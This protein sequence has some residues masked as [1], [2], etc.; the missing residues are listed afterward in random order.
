MNDVFPQPQPP[1][2]AQVELLATHPAHEVGFCVSGSTMARLQAGLSWRE[3]IETANA[4]SSVLIVREP[5]VWVRS[6]KND[7]GLRHS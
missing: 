7:S 5:T 2:A 6:A 1:D 4:S 3:E